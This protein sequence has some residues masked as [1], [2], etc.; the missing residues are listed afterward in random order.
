MKLK[1]LA[2]AHNYWKICSCHLTPRGTTRQN[3]KEPSQND[4]GHPEALEAS[5]SLMLFLVPKQRWHV[6][7]FLTP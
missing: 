2:E 1:W 7:G 3:P 5:K 6:T 4:P